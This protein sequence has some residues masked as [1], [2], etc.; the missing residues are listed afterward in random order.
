[1]S[2]FDIDRWAEI[3]HI[4]AR[5][6]KRSIMTAFG[7]YWGVFM[8]VFLLGMGLGLGNFMKGVLKDM[9]SNTCF[10]FT[11][12]TSIP[13]KGMP[14][15]R[16]WNFENDDLTDI[17]AKVPGVKY[18][19]SIFWGREMSC[20]KGE[21]NGSY[22]LMG[23]APEYN[24]I[25]PQVMLYGRYV[26]TIDVQTKRKVCVIGM[27]VYKDLFP[28]GGDP[29]GQQITINNY[30]YT[31]VGVSQQ[32]NSGVQFSD[33]EN[34]IIIQSSLFQQIFGQGNIV[35]CI[36]V[37][38]NDDTDISTIEAD[39]KAL[40]FNNHTISPEDVKAVGGF[41]LGEQF[42]K[43][44]QLFLG[45]NILTWIVGLGTLIAGIVGV[46]NIMLVLVK[47][48]V[49]EIGV[50]R[51]LGAK[52]VVIISQILSESFILTFIAG[53]FGLT[54][55]V[56][57]LSIVDMVLAKNIGMSS[58]TEVSFQISFGMGVLCAVII[59]A[60]SLVAGIIPANRALKINAVDAL[61]DE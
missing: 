45:L 10:F 54:A 19:A 56:G 9:S 32:G 27:K 26:N 28:E 34:T 29:V 42:K 46:S 60:G 4:I 31:V 61:R 40:I 3:W 21:H 59:I 25:N 23:Y 38:G 6:K 52:P 47:E 36:A 11:N 14:S 33:A 39:C 18:I 24:L 49:Q 8:L 57:T 22:T 44:S 15:G 37:T 13:Y 5:N 55:A 35:H 16:W 41:N 2:F 7:V 20:S 53:I 30:Y 48:R 43:I 58:G 51:A 12:Q 1:M 50:R 17:K